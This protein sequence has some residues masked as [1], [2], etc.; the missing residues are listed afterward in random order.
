MVFDDEDITGLKPHIVARKGIVR[1]FQ[2]TT[3]FREM[4][5]LQNVVVGHHMRLRAGDLGVF[6]SSRARAPTRQPFRRAPW[7]SW[8]ISV[9]C[10]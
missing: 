9:S 7:K 10:T 2:E 5:V 1:T 4:T 3:I 8:I 6:F